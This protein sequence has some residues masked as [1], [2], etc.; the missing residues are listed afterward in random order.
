M[1]I[2][3][4]ETGFLQFRVA[5]A[6]V[7]KRVCLDTLGAAAGPSAW[8]KTLITRL[9]ARIVRFH[10]VYGPLGT[11]DGGKEKAPAAICR[12]VALADD[13]GSLLVWGD[14]AQTR[15]F[16][17]IFDCIEGLLRLMASDYSEPLNL[18]TEELV[19][20]DG[21]V[22]IVCHI[23]GKKLRKLHDPGKPQGVRGRN[24][25]N[26]TII[27]LLVNADDLV[28]SNSVETFVAEIERAVI[29]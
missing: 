12:K 28:P 4:R 20:I 23:A 26:S 25:D 14:G 5:R 1:G 11:Y 7:C 24:S 13:G 6:G 8:W 2:G 27:T 22:D 21:L 29:V 3:N 19:T 18:G 17:Y 16:L 10:N 9:S 15:S